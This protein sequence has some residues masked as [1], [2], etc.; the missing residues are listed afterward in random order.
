M[1]VFSNIPHMTLTTYVT[2]YSRRAISA[3]LKTWLGQNSLITDIHWLLK[4]LCERRLNNDS[5]AEDNNDNN[6]SLAEDNND[7]NDSFAGD[8][9]DNIESFTEDNTDNNDSFAKDNND[10]N[11][12]FA[13]DN[14]DNNDSFDEDNRSRHGDLF[15]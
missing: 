2:C 14:N 6:D 10:N 15:L 12:S 3:A 13:D 4:N 8:N 1:H 5:L 11:D 9:I 7:N